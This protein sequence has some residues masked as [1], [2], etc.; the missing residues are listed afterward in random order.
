MTSEA[1]THRADE[2]GHGGHGWLMIACCIPMIVIVVALVATGVASAG[3]LIAAIACTAMMAIMMRGMMRGMDH[4]AATRDDTH[5]SSTQAP[6]GG[7]GT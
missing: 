1:H 2:H 4:G 3:L 6:R 7:R 5:G